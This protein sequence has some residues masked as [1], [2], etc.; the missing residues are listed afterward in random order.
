VHPSAALWKRFSAVD[1]HRIVIVTGRFLSKVALKAAGCELIFTEKISGK[2]TNGRNEF[3]RLMRALR[4]GDTV[5]VPSWT[6]WRGRAVTSNHYDP[7][8]RRTWRGSLRVGR[9]AS[10]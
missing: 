7:A 10:S 5:V 8:A 2:S 1:R 9:M 3:K 4:P 6:A